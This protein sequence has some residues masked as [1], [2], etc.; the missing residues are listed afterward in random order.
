MVKVFPDPVWPLQRITCKQVSILEAV[1]MPSATGRAVAIKKL[2]GTVVSQG[3]VLTQELV[4]DR[5]WQVACTLKPQ[6]SFP[7]NPRHKKQSKLS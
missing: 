7:V 2:N 1:R 3:R 5:V 4:T 6:F